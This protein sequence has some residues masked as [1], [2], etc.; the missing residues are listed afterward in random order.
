MVIIISEAQ[1]L[2]AQG[3]MNS[4]VEPLMPMPIAVI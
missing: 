1:Q 2:K 4:P 3:T